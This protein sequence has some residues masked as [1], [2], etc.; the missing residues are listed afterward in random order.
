MVQANA[1]KLTY[2]MDTYGFPPVF[3]NKAEEDSLMEEVSDPADP[4]KRVKKVK[5]K[6]MAKTLSLD[7]QWQIMEAIGMKDA[8]IRQYVQY[9]TL[10]GDCYHNALPTCHLV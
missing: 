8:E 2:E 4:T 5:S 6:V 7:Y 10:H 1:D 9:N 3:P